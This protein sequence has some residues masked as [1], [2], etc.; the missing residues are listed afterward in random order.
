MTPDPNSDLTGFS[1]NHHEEL[2]TATVLGSWKHDAAYVVVEL[3]GL[4]T[5]TRAI[6]N[7][8]TVR[9]RKE[10]DDNDGA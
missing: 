10:I 7:A 4:G 2:I 6:R 5:S 3:S 8:A 9:R 1:Y